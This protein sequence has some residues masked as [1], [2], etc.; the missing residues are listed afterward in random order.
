MRI[1]SFSIKNY[2]SIKALKIDNL[3]PVNVFF[4]KNNV[5]KSNIL[6][7]LHLAFY[8]LKNDELYLPDTMFYNRDEYR[9]IQI[10]IDLNLEKKLFDIEKIQNKFKDKVLFMN[11][12]VR[13]ERD[14]LT[15]I[16]NEVDE[17]IN[18]SMSF[19]PSDAV[20]LRTHLH[21]GDEKAEVRSTLEYPKTPD[22]VFHYGKY[23]ML[24][25]QLERFL[26]QMIY[27]KC[28]QITLSLVSTL[29]Q[30]PLPDQQIEYLDGLK[31]DIL[32]GIIHDPLSYIDDF[33]DRQVRMIP[34]SDLRILVKKELSSYKSAI[35]KETGKLAVKPFKDVFNIIKEYFEKIANNFILIPNKEYLSKGPFL[36]TEKGTKQ[37]EIFNLTKFENRLASLIEAPGK[38]ERMLIKDFNSIFSNSYQDLGEIE[39]TKFRRRVLAIFDTGF[40]TLPIE[41]QGLGIQDLFLYLAHMI[42]FDSAIIAIE[43]PEGG[44]STE[45]Q[46]I[47]YSIIEQVYSGSEKQIFISSHSEEFESPSSFIVE[48]TANGTKEISRIEKGKEYE[49]KIPDI[50]V[51]RKLEEEKRQYEALLRQVSER[52]MVLDVLNYIKKLGDDQEID[53]E[54]ISKDLGYKKEKV[55]E[56]LKEISRKK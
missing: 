34:D 39:I 19:K 38:Q 43:E 11:D 23:K 32:A 31:R 18:M 20:R 29:N 33:I 49:K 14:R 47:L 26:E 27:E 16:R 5:G 56:I 24:Y 6:R 53:A 17:F 35:K 51:K 21:C 8:T 10:V 40:T 48:M 36:L 3:N 55:Q 52:Q 54:K 9:P 37:I 50:L 15:D 41:N 22:Y 45:N 1:Q 46:R 7:A 28:N 44:L 12:L 25:Q 2:R 4:G 30:Y 42:L 13:D